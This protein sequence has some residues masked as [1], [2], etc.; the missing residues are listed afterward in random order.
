MVEREDA[1]MRRGD[2]RI[3]SLAEM[4]RALGRSEALDRLLEIASEEA[5]RALLASTVSVSRLEQGSMTIRTLIN[6]GELGPSEERR[7]Q[8]ETYELS[9]Y[10]NLGLVLEGL[11]TWT[12][13]VGDPNAP[14]TELDLLRQLGKG[15][16]LGSPIIVDSQLWGEFYATRHI[17]DSCFDDDDVAY[18]EALVAIL[19][20]AI[21]RSLHEESLERLAYQDP[22]TG[23]WNR[24][25]LDERTA[26]AFAVAPGA[27]RVIT[28]AQIDINRLK[29]VN[30][31]LGHRAGDRLIQSVAHTLLTE[32]SQLPGS[33]VARVGGDEF[34]V[35]VV[36]HEPSA[37]FAITQRLCKRAWRLGARPGVSCGTAS[38]VITSSTTMT[39][40]DLFAAADQTQYLA[41][42]GTQ[43]NLRAVD[44][45][46][47]G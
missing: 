26:Q 19:S 14:Q 38:A 27:S 41:K 16:S 10:S 23:L 3:R 37:V 20:G 33:L 2:A 44:E 7:P 18:I 12:A 22:L 13:T 4:A 34:T 15:S 17:G 39:P 11:R 8:D 46:A 43:S 1:L 29:E 42:R 28:V 40:G 25:A 6:V 31:S 35:L 21:S 30:D 5:R 9:A 24:R 36:S 32:F 45:I 47:A